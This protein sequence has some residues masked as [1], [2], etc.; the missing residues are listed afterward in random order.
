MNNK[1]I[2]SLIA[3]FFL[4]MF[5]VASASAGPTYI[6]LYVPLKCGTWK[7]AGHQHCPPNG[8]ASGKAGSYAHMRCVGGNNGKSTATIRSS[9]SQVTISTDNSDGHSARVTQGYAKFMTFNG[10]NTFSFGIP[11]MPDPCGDYFQPPCLP[12]VLE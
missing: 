7:F 4:S 3:F 2:I 10:D 5:Y 1:S 12:Q 11:S 9:C 6:S 8:K